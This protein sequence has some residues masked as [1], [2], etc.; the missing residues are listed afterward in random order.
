MRLVRFIQSSPPY[1]PHETA[2][3]DADRAAAL[4]A[5]GIAAYADAEPSGPV[6][7][8]AIV[9]EQPP[10]IFAPR[11]PSAEDVERRSGATPAGSEPSAPTTRVRVLTDPASVDITAAVAQHRGRGSFSVMSAD[12]EVAERL[13][14]AEADAAPELPNG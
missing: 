12:V 3:F 6:K 14:K 10:E 8:A 5:K 11:E 4:V 2:G 7:P 1:L 13:T 9:G